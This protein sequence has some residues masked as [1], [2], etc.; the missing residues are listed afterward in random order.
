ME[1]IKIILDKNLNYD[2][3]WLKMRSIHIT[4]LPNKDISGEGVKTYIKKILNDNNIKAE[5]LSSL[6]IPSY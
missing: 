6:I 5:L 3:D 1:Y 4:G 2:L